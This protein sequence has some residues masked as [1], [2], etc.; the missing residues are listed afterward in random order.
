MPGAIVPDW[1]KLVDWEKVRVEVTRGVQ[2]NIL[3]REY[4]G[5]VISYVQFWREYHRKYPIVPKVFF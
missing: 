5:D 2:M 1:A 3:A 4:A